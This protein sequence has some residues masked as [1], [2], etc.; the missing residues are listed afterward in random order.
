MCIR[1]RRDLLLQCC[2]TT[3]REV[4]M[5]LGL[6]TG[7]AD[8]IDELNP[9]VPVAEDDEDDAHNKPVEVSTQL[10]NPEDDIRQ[11]SIS[12][13]RTHILS[14]GTSS[15]YRYLLHAM[16]LREGARVLLSKSKAQLQDIKAVSYTHLRAHETPEH[17][18]CRL[19]LEKKKQSNTYSM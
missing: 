6:T 10:I 13:L 2:S 1:D 4:V 7:G 11:K 18:V 16:Y 5:G 14:C 15:F 12:S 3:P 19:L 17:L 8:P 9:T